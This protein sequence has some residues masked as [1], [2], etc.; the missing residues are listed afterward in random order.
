MFCGN[1]FLHLN[2][3]LSHIYS[4]V[5]IH[6]HAHTH[7]RM[8]T[9]T[10]TRFTIHIPVIWTLGLV[11]SV[12]RRESISNIATWLIWAAFK[13]WPLVTTMRLSS[14]STMNG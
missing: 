8:H 10:H 4:H 7:A 11:C 12:A 1:N 14:A 5:H 13:Q 2:I 9:Y 3:K 6:M